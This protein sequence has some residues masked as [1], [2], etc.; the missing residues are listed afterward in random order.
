MF[1]ALGHFVTRHWL[2]V[3]LAWAAAAVGIHLIAPRWDDVTHDGDLAYLPAEMTSVRAERLLAKAFPQDRSRSQMVL[4][5]ERAQGRLTA[6]DYAVADQL[7]ERLTPIEPV[8]VEGAK[9]AHP[10]AA[11]SALPVVDVWSYRTPV[12]GKKLT[13]AFQPAT[14]QA[15]LIVAQLSTE[16]MATQNIE[17]LGAVEGLLEELKQGPA[18]PHGLHLGI[19][20]SAAVGGDM[21]A[22]AKES[23]DKT[24]LTTVLL[25]VA[26][27]LLVYRAPLLVVVPLAAIVIS[28]SMAMDSIALATLFT[29]RVDWFHFKVFKTTKIFIITILFGSGTNYCL[30][31]IARYREE[32]GRG[33]ATAPALA[34]T[35]RQV[36]AALAASAM[37]T[38][39]GLSMMV[40]SDFG[41][42]RYSGPVIAVCLTVCLLACVTLAPAIVCALGP[43]V[44]WPFKVDPTSSQRER[45]P[46]LIDRL[47]IGTSDWIVRRPGPILTV[48]IALLLF[49]AVAGWSVP[50]SYN[51]INELSAD[52]ASVVGTA[53]LRR[54]FPA[55]D[56]GPATVVVHQEHGQL[57]SKA[58]ERRIAVLTKALYEVPGVVAVRSLAEPLG[59]KPGFFNPFRA[60]GQRKIIAKHNP[61]ATAKF[62]SHAPEYLG[63]VTLLEVIFEDD[64]FSQAATATLDRI[65][66]LLHA[67]AS[68]ESSDWH[69]AQFDVTGTTAGTRDLRVV[70]ESDQW[71]IMQLVTIAVLAVIIVLLRRPVIC[72][73]LIA[74]VVFS[75]LVT[76]GITETFF[77]WLYAGTF[78]GLDWKVPMFLFVILVAIGQDYNIYLVTRVFEEQERHGAIEGLRRAV[79]Q[80]GGI[81]TSCGIIMAGSFMSML[82]GSLRGMLELGFAL[83]LGILLD[84]LVV[85]SVLVPAFLAIWFRRY[86][87][88]P[89]RPIEVLA[90]EPAANKPASDVDELLGAPA[91][92]GGWL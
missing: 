11:P 12:L 67:R 92:R 4:V 54:H 75:Y 70:I 1:G 18:F 38:I 17:V 30:F 84:T 51:L 36:G 65:T 58:G 74:S 86:D 21:L 9:A 41:K 33:L 43:R 28:V 34:I 66:T 10:T 82:T 20:G 35:I 68:D 77:A 14:G 52:R 26:I 39:F 5:V 46:S 29:D 48:S 31:L 44:F 88:A 24:E 55:G 71:R 90:T 32:L 91:A 85:R 25:V 63:S 23:I 76:I 61:R 2:L 62:L 87:Q 7:I 15:T 27:L 73:Y 37:T 47:W 64:P 80:T 57:D 6:E 69:G 72:L 45:R 42:F 81:I 3:I 78:E 16:F 19:S 8:E 83:T 13:S 53:M 59:D 79:T 22:A 60:S 89:V 50:I 49:P 56:T 40:F